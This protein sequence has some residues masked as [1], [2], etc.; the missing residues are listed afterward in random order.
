[1]LHT[2]NPSTLC[3]LCNTQVHDTTHLFTCTH[4]LTEPMV[5]D[6][7][8]NSIQVVLLLDAWSERTDELLGHQWTPL[9]LTGEGWN[10][11]TCYHTI[12]NIYINRS[13]M[14]YIY[15]LFSFPDGST[16]PVLVELAA[17]AVACHIPF[18]MVEH[19][20]LPIPEELQLRIAFWS[21]AE[22]EEDIR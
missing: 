2:I 7:S 15:L 13:I 18:E 22:N 10:T 21:F 16:V 11:S 8:K 14:Y 9:Y 19:F 12:T 17:Q 3:P 1:M 20:H 5:L 4:V 6:L